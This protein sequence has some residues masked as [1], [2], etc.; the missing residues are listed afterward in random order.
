MNLGRQGMHGENTSTQ[1]RHVNGRVCALALAALTAGL[2]LL[3]AEVG[4]ACPFCMAVSPTITDQIAAGTVAVIVEVPEGTPSRE[5]DESR[6]RPYDVVKILTGGEQLHGAKQV[7]APY[8]ED[9]PAGTRALLLGAEPPDIYWS[10]PRK[11]TARAIEHIEKLPSVPK[12]GADRLAYFQELLNDPDRIV[13]DD[14][15]NEFA[16]AP[17]ED[18]QALKDRMNHDRLVRWI[19]DPKIEGRFRR[20]FLTMLGVCGGPAD[21][22]MLK[23]LMLSDNDAINW[24]L[25]ASIACYLTLTGEAGLPFIEER[26]LKNPDAAFS[27][28]YAT[29]LAIRFHGEQEKTIPR[30]RLAESLHYLLARP[31]MA[32]QVIADLARWEDWSVIDRLVTLFKESSGKNSFVRVPVAMYLNACPLPE[33][34]ARLAELKQLDPDIERRAALFPFVA[35]EKPEDDA[36]SPNGADAVPNKPVDASSILVAPEEDPLEASPAPPAVG[37]QGEVIESRPEAPAPA[38]KAPTGLAGS[39][40]VLGAA[41]VL[42]LFLLIFFGFRPHAPRA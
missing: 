23:Q 12:E 15:Y 32:D 11:M 22:P 39:G 21:V 10:A 13:R 27:K 3:L 1:Q 24:S 37:P 7:S 36:D 25:D 42:G 34:K 30:A 4:R 20:L 35:L 38:S 31:E 19:Q 28:V 16:K 17:Y 26:F 41:L 6:V 8:L 29:V 40:I 5:A 33:A 9:W 2:A 18:V 14:A